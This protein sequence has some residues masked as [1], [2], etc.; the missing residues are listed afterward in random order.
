MLRE[1]L[2]TIPQHSRGQ[3]Q[4]RGALGRQVHQLYYG[5]WKGLARRQDECRRTHIFVFL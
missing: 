5:I 4:R 1:F 3:I 2:V